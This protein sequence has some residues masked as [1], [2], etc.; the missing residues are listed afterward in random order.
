MGRSSDA[1]ERLVEATIDLVWTSTYG[2]VGVDAICEK[3]GVKKGSFYHFFTSKDELVVAALDHQWVK[4]QVAMDAI[5]SSSRPPLER[6]QRYLENVYERQAELRE[7]YGHVVGCLHNSVGSSCIQHSPE[8]T[9]KVQEVISG[10]RRYLETSLRDAHAEGV[11]VSNEPAEDAKV[12]FAYVQGELLQ[13][14]IHDDPEPLREIPRRGLALVG[15]G[16][17]PAKRTSAKKDA[18]V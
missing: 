6:L 8:L 16:L 10:L 18:R 17:A 13:A 3:A 9:A 12:L 5:F 11:L 4:R 1:R 14:R 15:A 7:R 2:T